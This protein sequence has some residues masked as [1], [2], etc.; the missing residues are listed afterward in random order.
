[1]RKYTAFV[2]VLLILCASFATG[3]EKKLAQTG[4]QFL[5]VNSDAR[6]AALAGAMTTVEMG[7][8]SLFY[9]PATMAN[10]LTRIDAMASQNSWIADIKH[11]TF[12]LALNPSQNKFGVFGVTAHVVD[13]GEMQGTMVWS[14]DKGYVDTYVFNPSAMQVGIGYAKSLSTKFSIGGQL[15]YTAQQFGKSNVQM[16]DSLITKKY[17]T[18]AVAMDFGTLFNTGFRDVKFG[19][20]VRNFS[21]EIKYIDESF[22]LPLTFSIGLTANLMNF[23]PAD[24]PNHNVDVYVDWAHPRSY[25]EYLNLGIEYSFVRKFF[26]RYGFEQNRDESGSSF[27]FGLNAFGVIFD[28]SYTPMKT[29]DDIQRFTLRVSL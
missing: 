25:P 5:S 23:I 14:N 20:T 19:M 27:G 28:Y 26:L 2:L 29:F 3:A 8:A 9:N 22:Q 13:Y 10:M 7:S 6:A 24:M 4:Y 17:K 21:N 12:S 1:M 16:T 11:N 15:K 18:N